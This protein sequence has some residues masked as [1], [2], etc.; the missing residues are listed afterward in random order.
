VGLDRRRLQSGGNAAVAILAVIG[1][2][3]VLNVI[4]AKRFK[5]WDWTGSKIYSLSDKTVNILQGLK[6]DVDATV[7]LQPNNEMYDEVRETLANYR[8]KSPHLKL[9]LLDTAREPARAGQLIKTFGIDPRGDSTAVV[10]SS[11]GRNKH[12]P[13][14]DLVEYDMSERDPGST[15]RIKAFKGEAAFTSAILSVT[16]PRQISVLFLKGHDEGSIDDGG[17]GGMSLLA[18]S[19]RRDNMTVGTTDVLGRGP[20][21]KDCDLLV[22]AGPARTFAPA[23]AE[24]LGAWIDGGGRVLA[25]IDPPFGPDRALQTL[26]IEG[27]FASRGMALGADIVLDPAQKLMFG[28]AESFGASDFPGHEITN[29]LAGTYIVLSLARSA[30]PIRPAPEGWT[31]S[32]LAR[33]SAEG[34]AERDLAHLQGVTKGPEDLAGPVCIAGAAEKRA[35]GGPAGAGGSGGNDPRYVL[36]GDSDIARNQF[37]GSSPANMDFIMNAVH[38]LTGTEEQIG[39]SPREPEQVHLAMTGRQEQFVMLFTLFGLPGLAIA[40]GVAVWMFRRR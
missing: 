8:A 26:G 28:T 13:L 38:W 12:V 27:T 3:V 5:R 1:L 9:E 22:I 16:Q 36:V 19:L 33:T 29:S 35:Q 6:Q 37:I 4:S 31:I 32:A 25:L 20:L 11:G 23:E 2:C 15:P 14:A 10:F 34:W 40:G 24:A 17:R 18:E 39:I 30:S 21:P 7:L